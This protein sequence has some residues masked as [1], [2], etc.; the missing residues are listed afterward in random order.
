M[1]YEKLCEQLNLKSIIL[2]EESELRKFK[3]EI[4]PKVY[5]EK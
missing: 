5:I 4:T 2:R 3:D 1:T